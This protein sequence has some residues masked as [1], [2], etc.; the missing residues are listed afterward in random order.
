MGNTGLVGQRKLFE[1]VRQ[2][3]EEGRRTKKAGG[4]NRR[5][6]GETEEQKNPKKGKSADRQK[7]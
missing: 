6:Q 3:Q 7:N 1:K 5:S 4:K 2:P